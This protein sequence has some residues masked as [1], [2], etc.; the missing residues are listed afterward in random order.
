MVNLDRPEPERRTL[1][2][3]V[4]EDDPT[5]RRLLQRLLTRLGHQVVAVADAEA[6]CRCFEQQ[7]PNLLVTDHSLP[8][9]TGSELVVWA[10][11]RWPEVRTV[12]VTGWGAEVDPTVAD[13]VLAKP[14]TNEQM[15]AM[16]AELT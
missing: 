1:R 11:S 3:V 4:V 15:T 8:G 16:I 9:M 7:V 6:A 5:V 10:R 2:V 12:L 14:Y 13:R